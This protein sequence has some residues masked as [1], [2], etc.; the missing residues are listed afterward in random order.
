MQ[1]VRVE[2]V[3]EVRGDAERLE[4]ARFPE[5]VRDRAVAI[6][7]L[8]GALVAELQLVRRHVLRLEDDV[9]AVIQLPVSGEDA[10]LLGEPRVKWCAGE[11]REDGE[12]REVDGRV[13]R[14]LRRR[15]EHVEVIVIEA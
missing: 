9:L 2:A 3:S 12:A 5:A 1:V 11:R 4:G 13:D 7:A 15:I 8:P 14:E 6:D 10:I